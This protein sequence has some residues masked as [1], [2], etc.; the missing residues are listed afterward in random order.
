VNVVQFQMAKP[1]HLPFHLLAWGQQYV[2][3]HN[4]YPYYI[5]PPGQSNGTEAVH[6]ARSLSEAVRTAN[7]T[8]HVKD[9]TGTVNATAGHNSGAAGT[10]PGTGHGAG[11]GAAL[12]HSRGGAT[13]AQLALFRADSI[14]AVDAAKLPRNEAYDICWPGAIVASY[15]GPLNVV[16]LKKFD[17][18]KHRVNRHDGAHAVNS[19]VGAG[20]GRHAIPIKFVYYTESDQVVRYDSFETLRALSA[21]S[22]DTTFFVGK[23]REKARDSDPQDYM[24]TLSQWR[25]CGAPGYSLTWPKENVVRMD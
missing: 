14:P 7:S 12:S 9:D 13:A 16:Y 3:V 25:E 4:C 22:N 17:V 2:R 21:A 8:A 23:R 15:Q 1:A 20:A 18:G 10:S 5:Y 24:G 19:T 11:T 6:R